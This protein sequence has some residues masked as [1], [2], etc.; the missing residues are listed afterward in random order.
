MR[1]LMLALAAS[2]AFTPLPAQVA[3]PASSGTPQAQP[4]VAGAR[5]AVPS[6]SVAQNTPRAALGVAIQGDNNKMEVAEVWPGGTGD[7]MG[8]DA[9]DVIT[10]A[11]GKRINSSTK[12]TAYIRSLKVGDAVELT[13]KRKGKILQLTGTAMARAR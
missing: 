10:H 2:I 12:L 8:V 1:G 4:G 7:L 11:G 5:A 13:V 9:G 6:T 3:A